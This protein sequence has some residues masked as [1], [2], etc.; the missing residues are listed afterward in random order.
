MADTEIFEQ[1]PALLLV[2]GMDHGNADAARAEQPRQ[3]QELVVLLQ[4][5]WRGHQDE[6]RGPGA[7][8]GHAM[9]AALARLHR[10][11]GPGRLGGRAEFGKPGGG[12]G[13]RGGG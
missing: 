7:R 6:T 11:R 1:K 8:Y 9:E 13:E 2:H 4:R 3:A 10:Q 5:G 12:P